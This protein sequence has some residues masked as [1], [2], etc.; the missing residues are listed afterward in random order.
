[1]RFK[2]NKIEPCKFCA[3]C[4]RFREKIDFNEKEEL[5]IKK[6]LFEKTGTIYLY[7]FSRYTI[8]ITI[9][10]KEIL[11]KEAKKKGIK[12]NILPKKIFITKEGIAVY[13]YFIDADVCPFLTKENR[14]SIYEK[15][16]LICQQFPKIEYDNTE[17][18]RFQKGNLIIKIGYGKCLEYVRKNLTSFQ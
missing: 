10:E 13:D 6:A 4:C 12:I 9:K 5:N 1:M 11:E 3:E 2:C 7:P 8:N 17:F 15:R 16:P 18:E 14:C